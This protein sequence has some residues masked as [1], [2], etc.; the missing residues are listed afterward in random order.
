MFFT[1]NSET[2]FHILCEDVGRI[3]KIGGEVKFWFFANNSK[4]LLGSQNERNFGGY[5]PIE[6][7]S[8]FYILPTTLAEFSKTG[9]GVEKCAD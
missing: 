5:V 9:G 7:I 1:N 4:N 2:N 3:L 6:G 8:L